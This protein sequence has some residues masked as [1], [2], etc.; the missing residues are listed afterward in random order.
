MY[1]VFPFCAFIITVVVILLY[2][3][4]W[5]H[6]DELGGLKYEKNKQSILWFKIKTFHAG[7]IRSPNLQ[8]Q[9]EWT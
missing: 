1:T 7:G 3:H 2:M 4:F 6:K 5:E 9:L 8:F